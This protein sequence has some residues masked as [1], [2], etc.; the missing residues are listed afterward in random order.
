MV[1]LLPLYLLKLRCK[2]KAAKEKGAV[3]KY[4]AEL[5]ELL[6]KDIFGALTRSVK[7]GKITHRDTHT[8]VS[9]LGKLYNHLYGEVKE[10]QDGK[11]KDMIDERLLLETDILISETVENIAKEMLLENV[12]IATI[13]KTTKLSLERVMEIQESMTVPL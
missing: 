9:L 1:I 8:L 13:A 5:K 10:F 4:T 12:N 2:I 7:A 11:V 6:E 3:G